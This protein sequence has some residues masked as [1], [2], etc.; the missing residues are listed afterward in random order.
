M[1]KIK[2]AFHD[3]IIESQSQNEDYGQFEEYCNTNPRGK[4]EKSLEST[5]AFAREYMKSDAFA[6][7]WC[8]FCKQLKEKK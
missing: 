2:N 7:E 1:S 3:Q 4:V 5:L 8:K 6:K